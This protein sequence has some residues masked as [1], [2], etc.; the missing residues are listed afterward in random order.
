MGALRIIRIKA[1]ADLRRRRLQAFVVTSVL[2]LATGA[3]TIALDVLLES[4]APYD[5]AFAA[6]NGAHLIVDYDGS[7]PPSSLVATSSAAGVTASAG[8]W[9]LVAADVAGARTAAS[10]GAG[11]FVIGGGR[12][13]GRSDPD[14]SVDRITLS[15]GR[16]WQR[17]GEIVLSP[18]LAR[19]SGA[20]VG[21]TITLLQ[22]PAVPSKS[23]P[24]GPGGSGPVGV[25]PPGTTPEAGGASR[26][27][28]VVGIASSLATP[29]IFG[30]ASPTDLAVLTPDQPATEQ[31]L[32]RVS[33]AATAADLTKAVSAITASMPSTAVAG[34]E[35]YLTQRENVNRTAAIFVPIL[36]AFS[37]FA[38]VAA[39]FV[40]ADLVSGIVLVGYR[41]IG[42]MKAV[43]FTPGQ[44]TVVILGQVLLPAAVGSVLGVVI[45]TVASQPIMNQTAGAFGLPPSFV[46]SVPV[47]GAVLGAAIGIATLA[48]IGP[49]TRAGGLS[50]VTAITRG[51]A[52]STR[53]TGG[54]IHARALR[55]PVPLPGRLGSATGLAHPLQA[56]MTFGA[57]TVGVAALV[58]AVALDGSL[59]RVADQLERDAASPIRVELAPGAPPGSAAAV[60]SAIAA[61]PQTAESVA[62]GTI[63]VSVPGLGPAVPFVGYRGDSSW[64]G[65]A[66]IDGRWF[67]APGEAVAPTNF[68]TTTGLHVGDTV[69]V[70]GAGGTVTLRLVG[71]IFDQAREARDDLVLRG[72]FAD[73]AT[74]SPGLEPSEWEARPIAGTDLHDY[75]SDLGEQTGHVAEIDIVDDTT[76]RDGFVLFE[77]VI[78]AL[79]IVLVAVSIGGVFDTVLLETR[80][81]VRETAVLR[82]LGMTPR[83]VIAMVVASTVPVGLAA[84]LIGVPLGI[85]FQ[86]EVLGLMGQAASGTAI[87]E[88]TF[89]VSPVALVALGLSGLA[90]GAL[91]AAIPARRASRA[92]I[93][94]VL[95][96]E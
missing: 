33:P 66:L 47:V 15:A 32:Y 63:D 36:L 21:D 85:V 79:G 4:Q 2:L 94:S 87:P 19:I 38:L 81:R 11:T 40:I 77:S 23:G 48:A 95:Q 43:G 49:A 28:T 8:P 80:R 45:G 58:F 96:A 22:P 56:A 55:L 73:A 12:F 13:A 89:T 52:P 64:I 46:V 72:E 24:S 65:Y 93:V 34:V 59:V 60:D 41:D 44:V 1:L 39:A 75:R 90:I 86:R 27:E 9:P 88:T 51:T 61:D 37:I 83:Q 26:T 69:T 67:G 62:A 20:S 50:V 18:N 7:V 3:A 57:L 76:G 71:E 29:D 31:M 70:A 92:S 84:G 14:G 10:K 53:P 91:G 42:I 17:P 54:R 74:L 82:T 78:A 25:S 5:Q 16:W 6:A 30:W 68:F 35:T